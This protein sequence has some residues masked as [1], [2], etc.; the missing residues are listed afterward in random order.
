V[1][2]LV[3]D[4][5]KGTFV[6]RR[7]G[8]LASLLS[9]RDLLVVNDAATLPGSLRGSGPSGEPLEL[10]LA[11]PAERGR[12][13]AVL[14]GAGDWRTPTER[15]P[16][17]PR[18]RVGELV[19]FGSGTEA[20]T[21]RIAGISETSWRLVEVEFDRAGAA[22]LQAL[23]RWGRPVQYAYL[24]R[25]L[26]LWDVQ[27]AYASR[28]W[29]SE[30]P[31]AG[32]PLRGNVLAALAEREIIVTPLTH[33]AGLSS[34]GD[35]ALDAALPFPE[36]FDIPARTVAAIARAHRAGARVVAVGTSVVRAL[37]G[38][39][40]KNGGVVLAGPGRTDLHVGPGFRP[41]VVDAL[42][43]GLHDPVG[44]HFALLRAFAPEPLLDAAY[45]HAGTAGY[46][47]HEF[48]DSSL[49]LTR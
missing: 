19:S 35:A 38:S 48:G 31:S 7:I 34:T 28:P 32:R 33:A 15:R 2:L 8:D 25:D 24:E 17:P 43:T 22:L 39:A 37:E 23:Y 9:P 14:F 29:A 16:M 27:T 26:E 49:I 30:Q 10:R 4:V 13:T 12:W 44:S 36:R 1:K 6:D 3:L 21:A 20:L 46:L 47:W 11:Q 18:L 40:L 5:P 45:R 42:L 41:R